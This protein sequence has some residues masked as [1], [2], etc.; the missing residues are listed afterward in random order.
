VPACASAA[1]KSLNV[2]TGAS[3][4][5]Q[6]VS[7]AFLVSRLLCLSTSVR[8]PMETPNVQVVRVEKPRALKREHIRDGKPAPFE[9]HQT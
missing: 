1:T 8:M 6:D 4:G 2:A 5:K 7:V 3:P 9:D